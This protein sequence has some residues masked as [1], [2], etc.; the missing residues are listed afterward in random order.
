MALYL[1]AIASCTPS[2]V[3]AR[4]YR[5]QKRLCCTQMTS[6]L[7]NFLFAN[8]WFDQNYLEKIGMRYPTFKAALGLFLQLGGGNIVETGTLR[9]KNQWTDGCSTLIFAET[10]KEYDA[11]YLW[12]VDIS[13]DNIA[14]AKEATHHVADRVTYVVDDSL[15]FLENFDR[16]INLLYLDS[17]DW[18]NIEPLKSQSQQ[19]QLLEIQAAFPKLKP[20]SIV[21]LDDND[22]PGGGKAA[23]TK[24][25]LIEQGFTCILDYYQSLW[26]L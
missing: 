18:D 26:I 17:F 2:T 15:N 12:T 4:Y 25:F 24:P 6:N 3:E 1:G 19:H 20:S 9:E 13:P 14:V 5:A 22:L 16:E 8:G 7:I 10:L 23:L 21:L 11:G